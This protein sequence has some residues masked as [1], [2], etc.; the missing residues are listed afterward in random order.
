MFGLSS[1][2][3]DDHGDARTCGT[4][5]SS[6]SKGLVELIKTSQDSGSSRENLKLSSSSLQPRSPLRFREMGSGGEGGKDRKV[7]TEKEKADRW[8]D[9]LEKSDRA[10]GTIHIGNTKLMSDSLRFSDYSTLTSSAL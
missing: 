2:H 8:D 5:G 1:E 10:G 9:L 4:F 6:R 3:G 7:L